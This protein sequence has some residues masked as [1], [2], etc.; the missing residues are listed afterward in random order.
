MED[1][2]QLNGDFSEYSIKLRIS[3]ALGGSYT[4]VLL[5]MYNNIIMVV[6]VGFYDSIR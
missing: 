4:S 1:Y 2:Y 3:N 5:T 6:V